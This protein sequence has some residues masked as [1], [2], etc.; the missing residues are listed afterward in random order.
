MVSFGRYADGLESFPSG[1]DECHSLERQSSSVNT[2]GKAV[3]ASNMSF[4]PFVT[5]LPSLDTD[6][7]ALGH[8]NNA[9]NV[10]CHLFP[11]RLFPVTN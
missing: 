11:P 1:A 4:S 8:T 5:L 10:V 9:W 2:N 7:V 3:S 6:F